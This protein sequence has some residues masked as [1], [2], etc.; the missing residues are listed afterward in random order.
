[1]KKK[2]ISLLLVIALA[3]SVMVTFAGCGDENY[4]VEV[5]NLV[6]ESEPENIVVL[7]APTA[8]IIDYM[9]YSVKMVGR[10]DEVDQ[11]WMNVVPTVGSAT[12][13]D[14]E[15]IKQS[16]AD[17]VFATETISDSAK[18]SL[19]EADITVVTM[20]HANT[21]RQLETN[22][23]T[24]GKILGGRVEGGNKGIN[25]YD[26][27]FEEMDQV[28]KSV[29]NTNNSML[30]TVCYLFYEDNS[31]KLMTSGTYGDAL[32]GYTGAVNTAVNIEEN[33]VDVNTL[34]IANPNFIFYA[35]DAT[36][37]AIKADPV[38]S[39][40]TAVVTNKTLMVTYNDMNRQGTTALNTLDK[41]VGFMYP[42]LKKNT[43]TTTAQN[44]VTTA[45]ADTNS[46][47]ATTATQAATAQGNT[48]ATTVATAN[49]SVA[50]TYKIN[51]DGLSLKYEDENDNVKIMQQRLF[52]LGYVEDE[53][54]I[55][56]YYGDVSKEA[57]NNFQKKNGIKATGTADNATLVKLFDESAVK[58]K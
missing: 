11:E 32:L 20:S 36:L 53:G 44:D 2:I 34:K 43:E 27:L 10:S 12:E 25:S 21:L 18:K 39:K 50:D 57:V 42:S 47:T 46:T 7:D 17:I 37:N 55:T 29:A 56:G 23:M 33:T 51:L 52:D 31:L 40:L 4:P 49:T 38:L 1:M 15:K 54:N 5:A 19:E 22:Y 3:L 9:N 26:K 48:Q 28:K 24:L 13:P 45:T 30:Y 58:Y 41:M 6:I 16:E 8:D 35:D 14:V